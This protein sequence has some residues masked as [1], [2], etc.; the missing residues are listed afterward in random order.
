MSNSYQIKTVR[1]DWAIV[2]NGKFLNDRYRLKSQALSAR[3]DLI[4]ADFAELKKALEEKEV[5]EKQP[6]KEA[7]PTSPKQAK[8][9]TK[10]KS[11]KND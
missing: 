11:K 1:R 10:P 4:A 6:T 2:K 8:K 7:K 9:P 3:A 5:E